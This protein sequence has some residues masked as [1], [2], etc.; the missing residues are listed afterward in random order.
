MLRAERQSARTSKIT[1]DRLNPIWHKMLYSCTRVATVGV[2]V[3]TR[4]EAL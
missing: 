1:N 3:L 2:K 4:S